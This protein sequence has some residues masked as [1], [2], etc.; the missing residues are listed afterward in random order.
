M[1]IRVPDEAEP[2]YLELQYLPE[3]ITVEDGHAGVPCS[4]CGQ[5]PCVYGFA[6]LVRQVLLEPQDHVHRSETIGKE[7]EWVVLQQLR[8]QVLSI[9]DGARCRALDGDYLSVGPVLEVYSLEDHC[10]VASQVVS[11]RILHLSLAAI[12][13]LASVLVEWSSVVIGDNSG[14]FPKVSVRSDVGT[15]ALN[16]DERP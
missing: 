5:H 4:G 3:V 13:N 2:I 10:H 16:V 9:A 12:Q 11:L 15:G 7:G 1:Q 14:E 8:V 6:T